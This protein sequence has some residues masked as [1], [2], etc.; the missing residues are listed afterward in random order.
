MGSARAACILTLSHILVNLALSAGEA[1]ARRLLAQLPSRGVGV[2]MAIRLRLTAPVSHG[3]TN[4][5]VVPFAG[6]PP[7][8]DFR[9]QAHG[10]ALR[11]GSAG[12]TGVV[13]GG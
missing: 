5:D 3:N 13:V 1:T 7:A 11:L 6:R 10:A 4:A 12:Q 2:A 8:S 9:P